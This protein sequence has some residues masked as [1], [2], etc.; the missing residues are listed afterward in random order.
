MGGFVNAFGNGVVYPFLFIYLHNVRGFPLSTAGLVLATNAAVALVYGPVAG[1]LIDRVGARAMLVPSLLLLAGG[2]GC[3]PLVRQPWHAY[4]LAAVIGLGNGG[5]WPSQS[6][7]L[8]GLTPQARR[9]AT[10]GL[11]RVT[12]N[13]GFGIGGAAAG[14]IA[15]TTDPTSF[16]VLFVLDAATYVFFAL[17][18]ATVPEV[19]PAPVADGTRGPGYREALRDRV[20]VSLLVLNVVFTTAGYAQLETLP[21]FAKNHAH[22]SERGIGLIFLVNT[23][24]IVLAQLPVGKLLEGRRRMPALAVMT[25]LWAASWFLVLLGGVWLTAAAATA[26]LA[27]AAG[28]FGIGECLQGPTQSALVADLAPPRLRGR[29]MALASNSW[30]LGWIIGPAI[31]G[32]LLQ[33]APLSLW[34]AAA[35]ACLAAGL[36]ALALERLVPEHARRTPLDLAP[37]PP[38]API[39]DEPAAE[40]LAA[41]L[42]G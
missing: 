4:A 36:G 22:V 5:F 19:E 29:Y 18:L 2:F 34:P 27:F 41:R 39:P 32:Y 3:L 11:Q 40:R 37:T 26:L 23:I 10:Y 24:V 35:G 42:S 7:L 28:I 9:H 33:H 1:T 14:L 15:T 17:L 38:P 16:T 6:T 12:M 20:L 25:L 31:G 8:A 21:A 30:S 13:L